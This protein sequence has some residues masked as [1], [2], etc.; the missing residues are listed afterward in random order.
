[1]KIGPTND[2]FGLSN[3]DLTP[4]VSGVMDTAGLKMANVFF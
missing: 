4:L 1:M 2:N 3:I